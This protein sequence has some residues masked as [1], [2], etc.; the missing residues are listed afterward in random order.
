[1]R[2]KTYTKTRS[3]GSDAETDAILDAVP[4]LLRSRVIRAAIKAAHRREA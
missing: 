1:M 3:F 4:T 2:K